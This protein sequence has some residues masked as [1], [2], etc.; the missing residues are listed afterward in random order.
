MHTRKC[1]R[2]TC[3]PPAVQG[4]AGVVV[5]DDGYLSGVRALCTEHNVLM[6]ADEVQTGLC[7]TGAML[8]VDHEQACIY[9]YACGCMHGDV[10]MVCACG[11]VHVDVCICMC[12]FACVHVHVCMCMY[13]CACM[14]VHV[15]I[16]M[17][18]DT[19]RARAR[20]APNNTPS[21]YP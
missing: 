1:T 21:P 16:C 19:L 12:A 15:C 13:A 9:I 5:P 20:A 6:I 7:R 3:R 11:C 2:R 8:A 17:Y 18:T 10:C 4:E 14:H